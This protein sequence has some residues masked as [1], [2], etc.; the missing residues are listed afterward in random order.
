MGADEN[1]FKTW[2]RWA[3]NIT[4]NVV[5]AFEYNLKRIRFGASVDFSGS[6]LFSI[7]FLFFE[8]QAWNQ[9]NYDHE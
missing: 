4:K 5:L 8:I 2:N 3:W 6:Y 7:E 1:K 9:S